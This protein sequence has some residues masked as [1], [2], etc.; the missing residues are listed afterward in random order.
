VARS[1]GEIYLTLDGETL[2][3]VLQRHTVAS[4]QR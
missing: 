4:A 2:Q 3:T 1:D